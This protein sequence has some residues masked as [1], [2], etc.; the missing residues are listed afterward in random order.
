MSDEHRLEEQAL[1]QI[2]EL[3]ILGQLDNADAIAVDVRTDLG[4]I[5]Q[6]QA[7][8]IAFAGEGLVFQQEIRVKSLDIQTDRL[9]INPFSALLGK[10]RLNR[11][12]NTTTRIVMTERDLN[13]ALNSAYVRNQLKPLMFDV[14][15]QATLIRLEPPL[16][17]QLL[18]ENR[19]KF[20]GSLVV[21]EGEQTRQSSFSAVLSP[22]TQTQPVLLEAFQ[23]SP[24]QGLPFELTFTFFKKIREILHQPYL[25]WEDIVLRVTGLDIQGDHL[26]IECDA[27]I[28]QLPDS[29][30]ID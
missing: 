29:M 23:C 14:S 12:V 4:K 10:I 22:A 26:T 7:D 17:L 2:A 19:M 11:P 25:Q 18:P 27:S 8:S 5:I 24:G 20:S 3:G 9:D 13:Q 28:A 30:E 16:E 15:G 6:G 1:S 21:E